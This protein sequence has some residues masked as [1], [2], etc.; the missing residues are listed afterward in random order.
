MKNTRFPVR[1]RLDEFKMLIHIM[2]ELLSISLAFLSV[3][4]I[5]RLLCLEFL[6]NKI[7]AVLGLFQGLMTPLENSLEH[8]RTSL[9]FKAMAKG[10]IT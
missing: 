5:Q 8:L 3:V 7:A 10:W 1:K 2:D 9:Y 6:H 4:K